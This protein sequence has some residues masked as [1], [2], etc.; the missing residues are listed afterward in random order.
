MATL[1][2]KRTENAP[3]NF[4]VDSSCIDCDTCRWVAPEVFN[5]QDSQSVGC[6]ISPTTEQED[7]RGDAGFISLP[8]RIYRHNRKAKEN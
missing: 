2:R 7:I 4:Y 5:R 8:H 3:G 6:T 1:Q